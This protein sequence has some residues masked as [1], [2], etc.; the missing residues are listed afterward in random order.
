MSDLWLIAFELLMPIHE[1]GLDGDNFL[2][3]LPD[4]GFEALV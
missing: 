4:I 1:F 2:E 3:L